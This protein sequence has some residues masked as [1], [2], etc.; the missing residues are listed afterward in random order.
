MLLELHGLYGDEFLSRLEGM[1]AFGMFD[2]AERRL[3]L[4]RDR[5]GEKP[6][7]YMPLARGGVAFASEVKALR[8]VKALAVTAATEQIG[9]FLVY[10]HAASPATFYRGVWQLEPGHQVSFSA[11]PPAAPR[12]Y[13][14]PN[15]QP[16][17]AMPFE[18]AKAELRSRMRAI[19]RDRL[20]A[21]VPVGAFLSGGLDSATVVGVATRDLGRTVHTYS[22]GF[23]DRAMDES[24]DARLSARH[25]GS[26][27][28]EWIV[29]ERD[30]PSVELL[31]EH[32]DGPFGDSSAI[33]TYLVAKMARS[34]V[35][36]AVTG[37]GGDEVFG[38]Y[39]RFLGGQLGELVPA[40]LGAAGQRVARKLQELGVGSLDASGR[41]PLSRMRRFGTAMARPLEH[42]MLYW[43]SIFP[44]DTVGS[45]LRP[46]HRGL[47]EGLTLHSDR[48][49]GETMG[50]STLA[51]I[52][53]HNFRMYL[54]ED[55]L[56]KVD[57]SAMAV[58]LETRSPM[59]DTGLIDFVGSLPDSYKIRGWTTKRLL[60]ETFQDLLAPEL[61][62]RPKRGFGVPLWRW[63]R[64]PMAPLVD[65]TLRASD[66]RL[67]RY[68]DRGEVERHL[69]SATSLDAPAA[70]RLW[71]L[72]TLELW[73][74]QVG[75]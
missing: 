55:L 13:W 40:G 71:S 39:T 54:P 41:D 75:G 69:L 17:S 14:A 72:L 34:R 16:R 42:K 66:A 49:F 19:V 18:E 67:Y 15:F 53:H 25:L 32:H 51:R 64:G 30:L 52:L 27:H 70:A 48:I 5:A 24:A 63:L 23:E 1:F 28:E 10:G 2:R 22:I 45:W 26:V 58:S 62:R 4:A 73:L 21:D 33:P 65:D 38:G 43:N 68:L 20:D 60:R 31:V 7:F 35:T 12:R 3:V 47:A 56:V 29:T 46:E 11:G 6:L 36:V 8:A 50:Q 44:A 9:S 37:D 74:R 59:L 61:Q 57:R